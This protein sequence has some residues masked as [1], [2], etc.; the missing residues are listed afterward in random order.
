MSAQTA[1][2]LTYEEVRFLGTPALFTSLRVSG[3]SVP[4]GMYR[5]ELRYDEDTSEPCQAAKKI[6][7][8]DYVR[9]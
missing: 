2:S 4:E 9:G 8:N 6:L 7:V 3:E 5:Y 1:D